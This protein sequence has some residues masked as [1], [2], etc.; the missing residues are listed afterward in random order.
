MAEMEQKDRMKRQDR[1]LEQLL[2][3]QLERDLDMRKYKAGAGEQKPHS[4]SLKH[5]N[6]M[7]GIFK[8]ADRAENRVR[9]EWNYKKPVG[10]G[11]ILVIAAFVAC[12]LEWIHELLL[13]LRDLIRD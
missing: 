10:V 2:E 3:K 7:Y 11:I 13:R 4:F 8:M 6:R 9:K 12:R 5:R 1:I